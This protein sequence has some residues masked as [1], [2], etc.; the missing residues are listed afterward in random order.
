MIWTGKIVLGGLAF[1]IF[2][3]PVALLIG[4]WLG[5]RLD[6]RAEQVQAWN[7]FRQVNQSEREA[8][9][10]ALFEAV[11]GILGHLAKADGR[12][13]EVEIAQAEALMNRMG[14]NAEKRREAIRQFGL[15]KAADFPLDQ[16]V[17]RFRERT[18]RRR[19]VTL[20]LIEILVQAALAD[21]SFSAEEERVLIRVAQGLGMP[22]A[23]FRQLLSMLLAQAQFARGGYRQGPFGGGYQSGT[24]GNHQGGYQAAGRQGPSLAQ[25]YAVLGVGSDAGAAEVK[26]AY[27]KLMSQHHPDKLAS[28]GLSAEMIKLA[29]EKTAEISRAYEMIKQARGFK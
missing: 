25:A 28:Q 15:G 4:L 24:Q 6:R 13:T 9:N 17:A 3:N 16:V 10:Q 21:G 18:K 26:R 19:L 12:V 27:R 23:Q 5:H 20:Q 1:L 2:H 22:E 7:P 29:T 8:L 14:L 11:F